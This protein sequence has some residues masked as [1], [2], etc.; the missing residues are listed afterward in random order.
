M[1]NIAKVLKV[2]QNNDVHVDHLK[3]IRIDY[4]DFLSNT[5]SRYDRK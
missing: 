4:Q 5:S 2:H 3:R 1:D